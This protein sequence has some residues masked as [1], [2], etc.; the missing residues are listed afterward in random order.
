MQRTGCWIFFTYAALMIYACS[1]KPTKKK[2]FDIPG[3]FKN[4]IREIKEKQ[5]TVSKTS[6]YNGDTS[7]I[8]KKV[9]DVN[10]EK[11]FAIFLESDINKPVY[12]ANLN[13]AEGGDYWTFSK[14]IPIQEVDIDYGR[15]EDGFPNYQVEHVDIKIIKAN[16]ISNT[17][18]DAEYHKGYRY[19]IQ[20]TQKIEYLNQENHFYVEGKFK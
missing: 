2:Y 10:W 19:I 12:Y 3:Y 14:K 11:E 15:A 18:I 20:G 4:E 1:S 7:R 17:V 6:V 13:E 16:L 8:E 5:S 9:I